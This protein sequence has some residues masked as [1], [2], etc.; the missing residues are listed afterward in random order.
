MHDDRVIL[1]PPIAPK[2]CKLVGGRTRRKWVSTCIPITT[3]K[4]VTSCEIY[5][6]AKKR[7]SPRKRATMKRNKCEIGGTKRDDI[8]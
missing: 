7:V 1:N 4:G 2:V 3:R 5:D 6:H 8:M